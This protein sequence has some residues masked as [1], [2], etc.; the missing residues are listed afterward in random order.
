M[1]FVKLKI[2]IIKECTYE[3]EGELYWK[4]TKTIN[5]LPNE[6]FI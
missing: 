6:I 2:E 3:K 5:N 4:I 1:N